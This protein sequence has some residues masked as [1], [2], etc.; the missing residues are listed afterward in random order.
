[1]E[2]NKIGA[3][4]QIIWL[5]AIWLIFFVSL[6]ILKTSQPNLQSQNFSK[7]STAIGETRS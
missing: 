3:D 7:V 1:M 6:M 4:V 5:S 2:A